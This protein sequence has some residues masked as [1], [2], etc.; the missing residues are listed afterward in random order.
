MRQEAYS[1]PT[2]Q[3]LRDLFDNYEYD[4]EK[5]EFADL[6]KRKEENV[7]LDVFL[8]TD[9]M[10]TAMQWLADK[11]YVEPDDFEWKDTLRHIWMSKINGATSGFERIF[12]AERYPGPSILGGQN[13]VY[14]DHQET[15]KRIN[16]LGY[17]DKINL[18]DVRGIF[19]IF[20][21]LQKK[22]ST[23]LFCI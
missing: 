13:W 10:R 2:I 1:I 20:F 17:V 15:L 16:Y 18:G 22:K 12:L 3:V 19:I 23:T 5:K 21:C 4:S 9:I 6:E 11:G 7:M 14:F 8:N